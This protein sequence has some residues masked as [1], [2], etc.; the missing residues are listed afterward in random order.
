MLS[1]LLKCPA[2]G[3]GMVPARSKGAGGKSYRYYVCGQFHNKGK[4]VCRSNMMPADIAED[5]VLQELVKAASRPD[6]LRQL[7]DKINVNAM[8]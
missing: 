4:S 6:I 3:H 2:C 8:R 7:V 5:Q 1:G